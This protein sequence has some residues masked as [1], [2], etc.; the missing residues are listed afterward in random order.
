MLKRMCAL[1]FANKSKVKK[2]ISRLKKGFDNLSSEYNTALISL[3]L[4]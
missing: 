2:L 4:N 1:T 3:C